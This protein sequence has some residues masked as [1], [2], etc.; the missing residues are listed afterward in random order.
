MLKLVSWYGTFLPFAMR[1][2]NHAEEVQDMLT[3][4]QRLPALREHIDIPGMIEELLANTDD[5]G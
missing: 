5:V 2:P 3:S 1:D 4:K